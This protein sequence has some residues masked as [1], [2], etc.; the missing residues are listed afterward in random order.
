ML[1]R[2]LT[3][4]GIVVLG[5]WTSAVFAQDIAAGEASFRKCQV[6]HDVGEEARVK[7]GPPLNGLDGRKAGTGE[8]NYS[9]G[10]KNSGLTWSEASFREYIKDP[11]AK[12]P[13]TRMMFV[14]IKDDAEIGELWAYLKQFGSDG[15]KK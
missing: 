9:E 1:V 14:G 6:C 5:A 7:L 15:K 4:V 12:F 3:V 11:R 10:L 2:D 8:F 13:D